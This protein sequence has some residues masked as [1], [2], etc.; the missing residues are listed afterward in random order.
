MCAGCS[1]GRPVSRLS[2]YLNLAGIKADVTRLLERAG[3]G[4]VRICVFGDR[5]VVSSRTG[6]QQVAGDIGSVARAVAGSGAPDWSWLPPAGASAG[7][8]NGGR[9]PDPDAEFRR[10]QHAPLHGELP[11]LTAAEFTACLLRSVLG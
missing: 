3:G 7:D 9:Q 6:R 10:I 11:R 8:R 4:R 2:G 1:G 5:W